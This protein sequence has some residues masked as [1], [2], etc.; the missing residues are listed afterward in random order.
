M[1]TILIKLAPYFIVTIL[2]I[3]VMYMLSAWMYEA[4]RDH[5]R[6]KWLG[7]ELKD[8]AAHSQLMND[9]RNALDKLTFEH[10]VNIARIIDENKKNIDTINTA[11]IDRMY[12]D[13]KSSCNRDTVSETNSDTGKPATRFSR[14]ELSPTATKHVQA[15]YRIASELHAAYLA[16]KGVVAEANVVVVK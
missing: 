14:A 4:G 7:K 11:V 1:P 16:C 2:I 5:E 9:K 10:E 12:I 3:S 6:A 8:K 15:D 13:T